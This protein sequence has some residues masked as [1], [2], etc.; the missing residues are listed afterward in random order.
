MASSLA[1]IFLHQILE[2][3]LAGG[4]LVLN[5]LLHLGKLL[6]VDVLAGLGFLAVPLL[7][8]LP[9]L[10]DFQQDL[11]LSILRLLKLTL[12]RGLHLI[13]LTH[14][15]SLCLLANEC[16]VAERRIQHPDL[17]EEAHFCALPN[18]RLI[19][20]RAARLLDTLG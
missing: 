9:L 18:R 12:N 2:T 11:R 10:R 19:G 13:S 15:L 7:A 3:L 16:L 1:C 17:L 5:E 14:R 20:Q 6:G 4:L 8:E